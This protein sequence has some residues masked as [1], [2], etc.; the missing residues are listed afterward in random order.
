MYIIYIY[1]CNILIFAIYLGNI[2]INLLSFTDLYNMVGHTKFFVACGKK[3]MWQSAGGDEPSLQMC[4][5]TH[6]TLHAVKHLY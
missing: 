3:K 1:V 6:V 2:P 5:S 4:L